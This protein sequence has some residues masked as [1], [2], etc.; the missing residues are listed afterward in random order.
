MKKFLLCF[1]TGVL[2]I[3]FSVNSFAFEYDVYDKAYLF[4]EDEKTEIITQAEGFAS[5]TGYSLAVVTTDDAMGK[6]SE[7]FADEC[8]DELIDLEGWSEDSMLFLID[9]DNREIHISTTG[10]AI[11]AYSDSS[12]DYII[13]SGYS[14]LTDGDYAEA[15][16]LMIETAA[17]ECGNPDDNYLILDGEDYSYGDS[18]FSGVI[19][20]FNGK[21]YKITDDGDWIPLNDGFAYDY[22]YNYNSDVGNVGSSSGFKFTDALICIAIGLIIAAIVVFIVMS[23][24]KNMGKGDEFDEDDMTL[25]LTGSSDNIVSRNVITTR[26][27]KNNNR[28]GRA[29]GGGFSGGGSSVHRSG[30][31]RSHGGGGRKF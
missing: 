7:E 22:D 5:A 6:T 4:T 9:M 16:L 23:R 13:D 17:N 10:E 20:D 27:P 21:K 24:Y 30:G 26:I 28:G 3:S 25:S 12:I 31:G 2:L 19:V 18:D 8:H 1:I 29:G 15:I 11:L 14:E